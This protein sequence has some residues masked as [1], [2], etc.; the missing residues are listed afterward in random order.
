[1]HI[2]VSTKIGHRTL[3]RNLTACAASKMEYTCYQRTNTRQQ[4]LE[5]INKRWLLH[6]LCALSAL[7]SA[8]DCSAHCSTSNCYYSSIVVAAQSSACILDRAHTTRCAAAT[9]RL[10]KGLHS[11]AVCSVQQHVV[12][13]PPVP[14]AVLSTADLPLLPPAVYT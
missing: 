2:D 9:H 7:C 1:V 14:L 8:A 5:L 11:L 12:Q 10:A 3:A 4:P 13:Q 6:I